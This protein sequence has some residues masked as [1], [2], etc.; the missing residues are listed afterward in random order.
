MP[1]QERLTKSL[2][3]RYA[4][5]RE[6]GSGGMATVYLAQDL[7]HN[8]QVAVKVLDPDLAEALGADR[9]LREIETAANLTHPHILPLFDSGEADGFLFYVMPFVEG[10]SL[11]SRL[12]RER[13]LPVEDAVQITREIADALACAHEKGVIHRDVKP[14][15]ILLVSGHAVLADFGV[16]HAVATAKEERITRTGTSLGTPAYMSPEQAMGEQDLDGRSD[17]YALGCVLYEM[18]AGHPPF[19]GAQVEAVVRQHLVEQPPPVTQARPAV[20]EE[21]VK[22]VNRALSKSPADRFKTTGEMAAAL[23]FTTSPAKA[24]SRGG[25]AKA[26][27]YG[28][29]VV[30]GLATIAVIA[31]L[32]PPDESDLDPNVVAVMPFENLTGDPELDDVGRTAS[33][34]L[35]Q[36]LQRTGLVTV[37]NF[38]NAWVSFDYA[39][40]QVERG[41]ASS[42][43]TAFASELGAGTILHGAYQL[44]GDQICFDASI[45]DAVSGDLVRLIDP[46]CGARASVRTVIEALQPTVMG[47]MAMEFD[48]ALTPYVKQVIHTPTD[49]AARE[50][51]QGARG[52]LQRS[53]E[54]GYE[55]AIR[56]FLRAHE[57]DPAFSTS[58][59]FAA[60]AQF[61]I[62]FDPGGRQLR[63][64]IMGVL[65][66]HQ[67]ELTPYEDAI[68]ESFRGELEND[69]RR[70]I[71]GLEEACNI[72]PGEKACYNLGFSLLI[73]FNAP[74]RAVEA[75]EILEPEKGWMRGW[76]A[77]WWYLSGSYH[78]SG[79]FALAL[80]AADEGREYYPDVF[81]LLE[82]KLF[83]LVGLERVDEV[84]AF[85]EDSLPSAFPNANHGEAMREV[86]N[87]LDLH[88]FHEDAIRA[89][90]LALPWY[91]DRLVE[92][93]DSANLHHA[94]AWDFYFLERLD[95]AE[96]HWGRA[97][98]LRPKFAPYRAALGMIAAKRGDHAEGR[99]V[100]EWLDSR[101]VT[102]ARTT[103][104][105]KAWI[106]EAMGE[107]AEAVGYLEE[108]WADPDFYNFTL[109]YRYYHFPS[110]YGY[111]PYER[112]YWPEGR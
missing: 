74:S 104:L 68:V 53:A 92:H 46:I 25:R 81:N 36:A 19:T 58:L 50:F 47:A 84:F 80:E 22:V 107:R 70:L 42:R 2:A 69:R 6:I 88:G 1:D 41:Q 57:L 54:E 78:V 4:I 65:F 56:H 79:E 3:D 24:R 7:K 71:A 14:A 75:L 82:R 40:A 76:D 49:E 77:Y 110:L 93:P 99:R 16:A 33:M 45:T 64:S 27:I 106:A 29:T 95:E 87:A 34:V 112:L 30:L 48:E 55:P 63:D 73:Q 59:I 96:E 10:E 52:Y 100:I 32:W 66:E 90:E 62:R 38:D 89:W 35:T 72:A 28:G 91:E 39:Q 98:S 44:N 13:Q 12:T 83:A 18:L 60:W 21:V 97:A 109:F 23:A 102:F 103:L 101:D 15:N 61:N 11:R 67:S 94:L 17:Q 37:R 86:G 108:I 31:S 9:F 8:R 26:A 85:L 105:W 43:L 51:A 5:E 20:A 111:E